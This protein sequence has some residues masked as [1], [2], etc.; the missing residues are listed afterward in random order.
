MITIPSIALEVCVVVIGIFLLMAEALVPSAD[1]R[2]IG[3]SA[4]TGLAF[5]FVASFFVGDL[6]GL[7]ENP[8]FYVL[9]PLALF[10]KRFM[11]IATALTILLAMDYSAFFA[12]FVPAAAPNA[13]VGEFLVLPVFA[14]AGLM[15]MVSAADFV[16]IFVSL[17]LVTITAYIL[18]ACMRKNSGSLEAGVK[19][20]ILG[21][22]STGFL[23]FGI[24]WIFGIT[25]QTSLLL[26]PGVLPLVPEAFHGAVLFGLGLVLVALGFKIAAAPFQFWVPDVYQGA[27]TPV[28]AFLSVASK[29]AG[30]IVLIRV[31][32]PFLVLPSMEEKLVTVLALLAG[33]T[34]LY[35]NLAALPQ[36]NFKRL[37]GYSSIAHAGYL[38]V[39]VASVSA[40]GA[41]PAIGFYLAGY[42]VTTFLAFFVLVQVAG[43]TGRDEISD[44]AGLGRRAPGLAFALLLAMLSLAGLPFTMGFLGKF[45]IF[46]AAYAAGHY[47]LMGIGAITVACGFYYYLKVVMAMYWQP[48]PEDAPPIE[49]PAATRAVIIVLCAAIIVFGVFPQPLLGALR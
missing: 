22:L 44:F 4:I 37:M 35:G 24:T 48:A 23:V 31:L 32:E 20:L 11:L 1:K 10:F 26:L 33:L 42:L 41:G 49:T 39:G 7:R 14:C 38:L 9:D 47:V 13:G 16:M 17:E 25:R 28:T 40:P 5:V 46:E 19:Y 3:W 29:A 21:A 45:L 8:S 34:L 15:W 43:L 12:R 27:P 36:N 2:S 6:T 30:F 18:V